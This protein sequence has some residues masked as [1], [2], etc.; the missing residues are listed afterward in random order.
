MKVLFS[1]IKTSSSLKPLI[2]DE[3]AKM[4][5]WYNLEKDTWIQKGEIHD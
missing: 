2:D 5:K 3:R 4:P 1:S